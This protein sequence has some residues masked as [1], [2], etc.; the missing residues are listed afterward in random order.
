MET[1]MLNFLKTK[2]VAPRLRRPSSVNIKPHNLGMDY[3]H[4]LEI[5]FYADN[6]ALSAMD[7]ALSGQVPSGGRFLIESVRIF[8]REITEEEQKKDARSFIGQAAQHANGH[9]TLNTALTDIGV[10]TEMIG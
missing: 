9:E 6:P 8:Q 3:N 1:S 7:H 5:N 2:K 10:T 4:G